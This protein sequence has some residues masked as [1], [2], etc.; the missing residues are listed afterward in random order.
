MSSWIAPRSRGLQGCSSSGS[1]AGSGS[2]SGTGAGLG[3]SACLARSRKPSPADA[4]DSRL[5]ICSISEKAP[6]GADSVFTAAVSDG[7]GGFGSS[8]SSQR[9]KK[10]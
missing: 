7:G 2:G 3:L 8:A 10:D 6:L 1:G 9:V 5:Y 4:G